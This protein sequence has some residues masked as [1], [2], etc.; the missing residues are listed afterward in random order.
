MGKG[1]GGHTCTKTY[2]R[3]ERSTGGEIYTHTNTQ[4][5]IQKHI[6]THVQ[7]LIQ[8]HTQFSLHFQ[9]VYIYIWT[10]WT[11]RELGTVAK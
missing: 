1:K 7:T 11:S 4:T 5:Y 9:Y 2:T 10:L 8:T 3:D 6:Q